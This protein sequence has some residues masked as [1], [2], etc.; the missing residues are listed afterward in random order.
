MMSVREPFA[1]GVVVVRLCPEATKQARIRMKSILMLSFNET[2]AISLVM[3][4]TFT[5]RLKVD[6]SKAL[7]ILLM[8]RRL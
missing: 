6:A 3:I 4:G 1:G 2:G 7:Q 8:T 5:P